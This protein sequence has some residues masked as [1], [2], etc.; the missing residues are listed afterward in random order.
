MC[1]ITDIV[2]KQVLHFEITMETDTYIFYLAL[3]LPPIRK[4]III[5]CL[6]LSRSENLDN[7]F[8]LLSTHGT[9]AVLII[10]NI[11]RTLET[12]AHMSTRVHNTVWRILPTHTTLIIGII[13][14]GILVILRLVPRLFLR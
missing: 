8:D 9:Q 6:D 13:R 11:L 5:K 10:L 2:E 3:S 1:K 12:H 14:H 7:V 4:S